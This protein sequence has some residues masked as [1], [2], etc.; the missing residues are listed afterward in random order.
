[1]ISTHKYMWHNDVKYMRIG[2]KQAIKIGAGNSI[3]TDIY[4]EHGDYGQIR[5][6]NNSLM[7]LILPYFFVQGEKHVQQYWDKTQ[8]KLTDNIVPHKSACFDTEYSEYLEAKAI[9]E[10]PEHFI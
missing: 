6:V 5:F 8:N 1:M 3:K 2:E 10:R 7:L 9:D 4:V